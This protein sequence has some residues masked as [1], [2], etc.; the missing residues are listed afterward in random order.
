LYKQ[1]ASERKNGAMALN[2]GKVAA[3]G[4]FTPIVVLGASLRRP[5]PRSTY[6]WRLNWIY[7][8]RMAVILISPM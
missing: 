1:A 5:A 6:G 8:N 4:P 7:P 2:M 3:N